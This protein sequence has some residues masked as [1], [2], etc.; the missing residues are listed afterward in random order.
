MNGLGS[1]VTGCLIYNPP[2][3][4]FRISISEISM[5]SQGMTI[6]LQSNPKEEM[7]N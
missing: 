5:S 3:S 4:L 6:L 7:R 2:T 1:H